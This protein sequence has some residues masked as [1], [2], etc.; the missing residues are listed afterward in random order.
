M[1]TA[2]DL[3]ELRKIVAAGILINSTDMSKAVQDAMDKIAAA[4]LESARRTADIQYA[5]EQAAEK[6][7]AEAGAVLLDAK[8]KLEAAQKQAD[9]LTARQQEVVRAEEDIA[10]KVSVYQS[11]KD[12]DGAAQAQAWEG[13]SKRATTLAMAEQDLANR[14]TTL[15]EGQRVLEA[16][17]QQLK[18]LTN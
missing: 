18:A 6:T 10:A 17:M 4:E 14:E 2:S 1:L 12:A 8:A 11:Q 5:A 7:K 9:D 16:K 13:I 3:I 15:A